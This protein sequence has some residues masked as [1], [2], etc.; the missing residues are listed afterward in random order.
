[1]GYRHDLLLNLSGKF[2]DEVHQLQPQYA[3]HFLQLGTKENK[4]GTIQYFLNTR[5]IVLVKQKISGLIITV[6][7]SVDS[8]YNKKKRGIDRGLPQTTWQPC[9]VA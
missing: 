5:T 8:A 7:A 4:K 9:K 1:V 3:H 2:Q 6:C